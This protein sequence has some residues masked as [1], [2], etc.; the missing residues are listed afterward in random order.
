MRPVNQ[1][2]VRPEAG[3]LPGQYQYLSTLLSPPEIAPDMWEHMQLL[4]QYACDAGFVVIFEDPDSF[5]KGP[6]WLLFSHEFKLLDEGALA[7]MYDGDETTRIAL[8][9]EAI[10]FDWFNRRWRLSVRAKPGWHVFDMGTL[11]LPV[12]RKRWFV[13]KRVKRTP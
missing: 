8:V 4:A 5:E 1:F 9:D 12:L 6:Y 3:H 10:E 13:L 11:F 7:V 2:A